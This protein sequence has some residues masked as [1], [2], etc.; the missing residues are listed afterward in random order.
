MKTGILIVL[1]LFSVSAVYAAG[2]CSLTPYSSGGAVLGSYG[3]QI[4]LNVASV[5]DCVEKAK[6]MLGR[7][8]FSGAPIETYTA[9]KVNFKFADRDVSLKGFVK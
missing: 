3:S 7:E 6:T 5:D 2:N 1:S 9:Q 8:F 4:E